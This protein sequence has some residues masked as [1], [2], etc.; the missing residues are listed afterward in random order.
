[1]SQATSDQIVG[2]WREYLVR[3]ADDRLAVLNIGLEAVHPVGARV[4]KSLQSERPLSCEGVGTE[5]V[6]LKGPVE[7]PTAV[8]R[9]EIV[10]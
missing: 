1:M 2:Q 3:A 6:G 9:I 8:G 10:R 7:Q 5:L 4:C